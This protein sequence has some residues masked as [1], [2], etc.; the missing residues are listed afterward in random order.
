MSLTFYITFLCLAKILGC[1]F[2][3]NSSQYPFAL[4]SSN[5]IKISFAAFHWIWIESVALCTSGFI[6]LPLSAVKTSIAASDLVPV[7]GIH[8]CAITLPPPCLIDDAI[9]FRTEL[10]LTFPL[11]HTG[12]SYSWFYLSKDFF[13]NCSDSFRCF[14]AKLGTHTY[15]VAAVPALDCNQWFAP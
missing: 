2:W 11:H 4:L 14:L 1:F 15:C 6:L 5:C 9:Y 7:T 10:L 8:T 3:S 13:Q 12:R